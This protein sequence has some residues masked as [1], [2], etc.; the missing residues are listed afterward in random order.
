MEGFIYC[1]CKEY[2]MIGYWNLMKYYDRLSIKI[3]EM[4]DGDCLGIDEL[5]FRDGT[6]FALCMGCECLCEEIN[7]IMRT[8]E[9]Y[10]IQYG[11]SSYA[12]TESSDLFHMSDFES[13]LDTEANSLIREK[14]AFSRKFADVGWNVISTLRM[15]GRI[16]KEDDEQLCQFFLKHEINSITFN[17]A[18][19]CFYRLFIDWAEE[20]VLNE[21]VW[22][23]DNK[24]AYCRAMPPIILGER[25]EEMR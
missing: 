10:L 11:A 5:A 4:R 3:K 23:G 6:V 8:S 13:M 2:P 16:R 15:G 22:V 9:G 24:V 21:I 19:Y 14:A 12:F 25:D 18:K 17:N 7:F 20:Y 1:N